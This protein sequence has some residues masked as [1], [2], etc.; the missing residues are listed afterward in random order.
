MISN[1]DG[2]QT[3]EE[4]YLGKGSFASVYKAEKDG[5]FYAIK[6]F[7]TE[8]VKPEYKKLLNREIDALKKITHP[9][10]VKFYSSGTFTENRFKYFYII[11]DLVEGKSLSEYIGSISEEQA[12]KFVESTLKTLDFVHKQGVIHRDLKPENIRINDQ[13]NPI[14]LD[15]GLS[16]LID[17]SSIIQTGERVGTFTFMPPEQVTDS[18]HVDNRS[19]YFSV[20][21]I[22]YQLL[23]GK[24]PYDATNLPA[25]IDQIKNQY[26]KPPSELN[27]SITNRTENIILK[28]LEKQP[29]KR[30]QTV[31]EILNALKETPKIEPKKLDL[32]TRFFLRLLHNE[33]TLFIEAIDKGLISNVIFPSNFFK[34]FHP[35]VKVINDSKINFTTDPATNR[36]TYSAF[37][38]TEGVQELPYSSGSQVTPIQKKDFHSITQVQEYVKKVI[39]YQIQHKVTELAAPF[40]YA[41]NINDDWFNINIKLIKE[42]TD[43]RNEKYPHLPIWAGICMNIEDWYDEEAK[44]KILNSYVKTSPDGFFIYGDP[45]GNQSNLPQLFHYADLLRKLQTFSSVPVVACR[46]N[47]FGLILLA[48]G[49]SGISSGF[50]SLDNFRESILSD[51]QDGYTSDPR[52]YIPKLLSLISFKKGVP[53]KLTDIARSS[54]AKELACKC[55]YCVNIQTLSLHNIKMHFIVRRNAE[56]MELEKIDS[57]NR[58]D[59]I[60]ERVMKAIEYVKVLNKEGIKIANDFS[61]LTTW[62]GLI[63]EFKKLD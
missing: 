21:M 36:L 17:Y 34:R 59:Y 6:I 63:E 14:I 38:K 3:K 60:E 23:T 19:D 29:Y 7:Q 57:T 58:L 11:M 41:Q 49:I 32:S 10:I 35:T 37:S 25:L 15:F 46:V 45:I 18:K 39:D 8:Y 51:T 30:Y 12:L 61:Y 47:G 33:K 16:K 13:E 56:I 4:W 40:F 44:T 42:A 55:S 22:L 48:L 28:L 50:A 62:K 5:K 27:S 9:N 31:D 26:P 2:Y 20:G 1:I 43:Y 53:T 24:L 52:Y 54:I